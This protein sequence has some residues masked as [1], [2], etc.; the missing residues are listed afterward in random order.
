MLMPICTHKKKVSLFM[1]GMRLKSH[2]NVASNGCIIPDPIMLIAMLITTID[3]YGVL[4]E[5]Q[6]KTEIF[7]ENFAL[8][9]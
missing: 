2:N 3:V 1:G 8:L 9:Q 6:E 4:N 7:N 5:C